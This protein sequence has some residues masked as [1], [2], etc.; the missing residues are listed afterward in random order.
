MSATLNQLLS[1][2]SRLADDIIA[3]CDAAIAQLD[4]TPY[5][6]KLNGEKVAITISGTVI[7]ARVYTERREP[8]KE[9]SRTGG[10]GQPSDDEPVHENDHERQLSELNGDPIDIAG[11]E[12]IPWSRAVQRAQRGRP[13]I[14]LG[15]PG[16]GK[17]TLTRHSTVK[18]LLA[19]REGLTSHT[20]LPED[21]EP[22]LW[23]TCTILADVKLGRKSPADLVIEAAFNALALPEDAAAA[24]P[25]VRAWLRGWLD[26][27]RCPVALDSL[28]E[29]PEKKRAAF[30]QRA[31]RLQHLSSPLVLTCRSHDWDQRGDIPWPQ[32]VEVKLAPFTRREQ[33][34]YARCFFREEIQPRASPVGSAQGAE[35]AA[36]AASPAARPE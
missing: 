10:R 9:S 1:V 13:L 26:A 2:N 29:V 12:A 23:M 16:R 33:R 5:H 4:A 8:E 21:C 6:Y 20:L 14:V 11:R 24:S 27:G 15:A 28:D 31:H 7:D 3:F 19:V 36:S 22:M 35:L 30:R 32:M 34:T 17:T 25:R 18:R